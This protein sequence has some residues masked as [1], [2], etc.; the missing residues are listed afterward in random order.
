M[1]SI[2]NIKNSNLHLQG[3]MDAYVPCYHGNRGLRNL[4]SAKSPVDL[5]DIDQILISHRS[6][7]KLQ[8]SLRNSKQVNK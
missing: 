8:L 3:G 4:L 1:I 6:T 5:C 2:L 7:M